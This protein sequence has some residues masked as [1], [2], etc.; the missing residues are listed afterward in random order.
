[1]LFFQSFLFL[2]SSPLLEL[3]LLLLLL[4]LALLLL[5]VLFCLAFGF[6]ERLTFQSFS[7]FL[8]L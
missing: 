2:L 1:M 8:L 7:L 5:L 4:L 6:L 3:V